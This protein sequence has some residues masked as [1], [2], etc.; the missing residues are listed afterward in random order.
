MGYLTEY[1]ERS[2]I[3]VRAKQPYYD[4]I[5]KVD[6]SEPM[7]I[8]E[9]PIKNVYLVN[10][11]ETDEA[12]EE[13]VVRK[14][15]ELIF[16]EE[17]SG[18]ASDEEAWPAERSFDTFNQWFDWEIIDMAYDILDEDELDEDEDW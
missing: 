15:Y 18:F 1:V 13:A 17:L 3:L 7:N 8:K 16:A 14:F 4:W 11:E 12:D 9:H 6:P 2:G 10:A 5:N